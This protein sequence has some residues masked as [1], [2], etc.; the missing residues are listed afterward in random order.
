MT[1]ATWTNG[2]K[3]IHGA[4]EYFPHNTTFYIKLYYSRGPRGAC[5]TKKLFGYDTPE[6]DKWKLVEKDYFREISEK[7]LISVRRGTSVKYPPKSELIG[8][9]RDASHDCLGV[10]FPDAPKYFGSSILWIHP[11]ELVYLEEKVD[12]G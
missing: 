1:Q 7:Y 4:Y 10:S 6:W 3:E 5:R 8:H 9:I 11:T 12:N 2:K